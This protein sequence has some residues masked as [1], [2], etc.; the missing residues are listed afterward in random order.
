LN[1]C[2]VPIARVVKD[3]DESGLIACADA[4]H[5]VEVV[6]RKQNLCWASRILL[7]H[8]DEGV[9]AAL[10]ARLREIPIE[11]ILP[12]NARITN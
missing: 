5:D 9:N 8:F 4:L 7:M 6:I 11:I 12:E 1:P 10:S 3:K 2:P